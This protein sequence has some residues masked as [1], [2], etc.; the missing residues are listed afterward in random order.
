MNYIKRKIGALSAMAALA[1]TNV[2]AALPTPA[3]PTN[4]NVEG[5]YIELFK[6]WVYDGGVALGLIIST[7]ALIAVAAQLVGIY[8]EIAAGRKTWGDMGAFG[9]AGVVLIVIV[10]FLMTDASDV[11]FAAPAA[12]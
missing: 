3:A 8:R 1:A 11:I 5:N 10:V 4:G 12:A 7:V 9:I 2:Q 6:G